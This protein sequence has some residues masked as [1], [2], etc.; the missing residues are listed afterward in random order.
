MNPFDHPWYLAHNA[1]RQHHLQSLRLPFHGKTVLELGAGIGYHTKFLELS[2]GAIVTSTDA[3]QSNLDSHISPHS[4]RVQLLDVE[5][6]PS[7]VEQHDIVHAYGLLYHLTNPD[8]ALRHMSAWCRDFLVL[9]TV[10]NPSR[11]I[12][13]IEDASNPTHGV[14]S[15]ATLLT[16]PQLLTLLHALFPFVYVAPNHSCGQ[17]FGMGIDWIDPR[18]EVRNVFVASYRS[19]NHLLTLDPA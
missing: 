15:V 8:K 4:S 14:R 6:P 9:E 2:L 13:N 18:N 12:T 11:S 3:R 1:V 7:M 17:P 19:L 10:V 16:R 5:N